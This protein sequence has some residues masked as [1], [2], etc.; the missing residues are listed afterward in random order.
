VQEKL[1]EEVVV[2]ASDYPHFD[3]EP[4]YTA[5]INRRQ[6]MTDSQRDGVLRRAALRFYR[7]DWESI[8]ER[9]AARRGVTVT[10]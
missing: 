6:D 7:L 5:D 1:G 9:N 8:Q 4:P 10:A 2:W 3:T